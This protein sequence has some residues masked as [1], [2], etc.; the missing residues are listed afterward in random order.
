MLQFR[1]KAR[2]A[3]SWVY[4]KADQIVSICYWQRRLLKWKRTSSRRCS[5]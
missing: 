2:Q 5:L 4:P 3:E 1:A